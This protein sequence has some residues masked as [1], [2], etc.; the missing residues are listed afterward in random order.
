MKKKNL[1]NKFDTLKRAALQQINGG[2]NNSNLRPRC[3]IAICD[4]SPESCPS[5]C[6]CIN[7]LCRG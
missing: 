6:A 1:I 4:D 5:P 2:G 7:G 3:L